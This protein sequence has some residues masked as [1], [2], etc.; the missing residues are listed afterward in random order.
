MF[1]PGTRVKL[2]TA[3]GTHP[4]GS[5]AIVVYDLGMNVCQIMLDTG[6]QLT[7]DC[8]SLVAEDEE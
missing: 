3:I 2:L 4:A 8:D 5:A 6:E 7:L 1:A